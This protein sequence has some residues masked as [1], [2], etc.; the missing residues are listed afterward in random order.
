MWTKLVFGPFSVSLTE[1]FDSEIVV[2]RIPSLH[3][4]E[5]NGDAVVSVSDAGLNWA[6]LL[7]INEC[8]C[9]CVCAQ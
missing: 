1:L 8:A 2:L 4:P 7:E 9:T 6:N 3:Q 5:V